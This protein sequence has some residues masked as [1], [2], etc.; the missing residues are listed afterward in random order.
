MI[1]NLNNII[2]IIDN[3]KELLSDADYIDL[4]NNLEIIYKNYYNTNDSNDYFDDEYVTDAQKGILCIVNM[5]IIGTML[6]VIGFVT[7]KLVY[8]I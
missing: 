1:E 8:H 3:N 4:C 2:D 7:W 6:H 5:I